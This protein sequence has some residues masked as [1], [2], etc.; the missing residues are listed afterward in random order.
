MSQ[1][2]TIFIFNDSPQ[3]DTGFGIVTREIW[4]RLKEKYNL[5]FLG[6]N[7]NTDPHPLAGEYNIFPCTGDPRGFDRFNSVINAIKPDLLFT[8]NDY[9]SWMPIIQPLIEARQRLNKDIPWVSMFPVDGKPVYEEYIQ[10]LKTY[11][12][13]PITLTKFGQD[14]ILETDPDFKVPY[15]YHGVDTQMFRKL[16]QNIVDEER[17]RLKL[18][19]KFVILMI[20]VNQVRKQYN[21]ALEAFADFAKD[22][23]NAHLH[24]H[25]QKH[26]NY[27]WDLPRL[28][29]LFSKENVEKGFL[30]IKDRVTF[31]NGIFGAQGI[32][33]QDLVM[34]YNLADCFLSTNAGE[35][36]CLPFIE[37]MACELPIIAPNST[38]SP[39]ICKDSAL[40]VDTEFDY[41]F[42]FQD[43]SLRRPIPNKKQI[44][45]RLH[46]LYKNKDLRKE[47]GKNGRKRVVGNSQFNWDFIA[48]EIDSILQE[49]FEDKRIL[50]LTN[51]EI[52]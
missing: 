48:G 28:I 44:T 49:A 29:Q 33:K 31:T 13:Y 15:L 35:G 41:F 30:P 20:G 34:I 23:P 2:K 24:L 6:I 1:K 21:L 8:L 36:F 10:M 51:Q 16:D 39:E 17:K 12:D 18:D 25:T 7:H 43:R 50:D 46:D 45:E 14:A 40:Y 19:N 37:S 26:T 52:L 11:V 5:W 4:S 32:S 42:P 27:G 47:L 22:K 9:D 3:A 38:V